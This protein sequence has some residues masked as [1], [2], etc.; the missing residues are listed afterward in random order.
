MT[1][2]RADDAEEKFKIL[3]AVK[4]NPSVSEEAWVDMVWDFINE[5]GDDPDGA[6][7][8]EMLVAEFGDLL[9]V[10]AVR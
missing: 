3:K 10:E 1:S 5:S 6:A 9:E 7:V 4:S 8:V 2:V